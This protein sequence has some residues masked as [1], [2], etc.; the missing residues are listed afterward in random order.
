MYV[1]WNQHLRKGMTSI[2]MRSP[3]LKWFEYI[4]MTSKV[5]PYDSMAISDFKWS[6]HPIT[7]PSS[8]CDPAAKVGSWNLA[9]L[10]AGP[11]WVMRCHEARVHY[12]SL[13]FIQGQLWSSV[14]R[15]VEGFLIRDCCSLLA[16]W[17]IYTY[18][19]IIYGGCPKYLFPDSPQSLSQSRS[20]RGTT[21]SNRGRVCSSLIRSYT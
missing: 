19:Y 9:K 5:T 1:I 17:W 21:V 6:H 20:N 2:E 13:W 4:W 11:S 8:H 10:W 12:G 7:L 14:W 3:I 18:I 16:S 15:S